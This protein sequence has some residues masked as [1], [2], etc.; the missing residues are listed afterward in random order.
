MKKLYVAPFAVAA[1][2]FSM[3][4]D[5]QHRCF[6]T[7]YM[8]HKIEQDPSILHNMEAIEEHTQAYATNEASMRSAATTYT[9][10]V[11][12]HVVYKGASENVPDYVILGQLDVLNEDFTATNA[13]LASVVPAFTGIIG[14]SDIDFCLATTAPDGSPTT[15]IERY[16]TTRNSF[17]AFSDNVKTDVPAW[18]TNQYLNI[19]VC[20]I[21][22]G[23][24]GYAQFP[25]G[26]AST[27]GV[28]IDYQYTGR[29]SW[30]SGPLSPYNLGRTLTHEVGHWLNLRHIWGD[31]GCSVDDGVADTP[32][33]NG[34]NYGCPTSSSSCS[35]LD[36][37]QNFMDYSD[38][39][40]LV[41]F[42]AGQGT[43]MRATMVSGGPRA[44]NVAASASLCSGVT[45]TCDI[46]ANPT[47]TI[48][49]AP[50]SAT[51][52]WDAVSGASGYQLRG[53][54]FGGPWRDVSIGG[55]SRTFSIFKANRT[56][57]WEV[58]ADCGASGTSA[59]TATQTFTM[60][61][62]RLESAET[63]M[64]LFP[65]P[66]SNQ[67]SVDLRAP[68]T[69]NAQIFVT[70]MTGRVLKQKQAQL[71]DL[72]HTF[73]FDVSDLADGLYMVRLEVAG[74]RIVQSF[75]VTR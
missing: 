4:A 45:P 11:V 23:I 64:L 53:R 68:A 15:G 60:P 47:T 61:S 67:I 27:D 72:N 5:A 75:S 71:L 22:G 17:S 30:S 70:D 25:G 43:R 38:D 50:T 28:V 9:I 59:F 40:C 55:T 14:N 52:S 54:I 66:A 31:G 33:S 69:G 51:T 35:S 7:E 57:Q 39:D 12:F 73:N 29:D 62:S 37:V 1:L 41:M 74:E 24:L 56:Y 58:R 18:N 49:A 46:P 44:S 63:E 20:D 19:W 34:A 10:P 48:V 65:N 3:N 13:D 21:G 8:Q 42:S 26:P 32:V 16:T 2:C 6:S 36:N